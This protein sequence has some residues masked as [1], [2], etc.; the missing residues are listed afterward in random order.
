MYIYIFDAAINLTSNDS[1]GNFRRD[2]RTL[3]SSE[4]VNTYVN[5]KRAG[6]SLT[7]C[8]LAQNSQF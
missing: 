7:Y 1:K 5:Y 8:K 3:K 6:G 4:I 2:Q